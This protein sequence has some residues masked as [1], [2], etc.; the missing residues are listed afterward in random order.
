MPGVKDW[1][2][3]ASSDLLSAKKLFRDDDDTLDMAA[4][5]THQCVEKALKCFLVFLGLGIPKS[6]DLIFL[7]EI[8]A[9]KD[10][11]FL[12]LRQEAK[13]LNHYGRDSRYPDDYFHVDRD[14]VEAA[15][16]M[17]SKALKFVLKKI[18]VDGEQNL[19]LF[20]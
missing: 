13:E 3:K 7:L 5:H 2:T 11:D 17:A 15:I 1:L 12:C 4:Y 6:H 16:T 18:K 19:R 20:H 10:G 9:D 8:C 14:D